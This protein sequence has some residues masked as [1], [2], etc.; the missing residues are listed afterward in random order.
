MQR[1]G[2]GCG[3]VRAS[4]EAGAVGPGRGRGGSGHEQAR[5]A[6]QQHPGTNDT[7]FPGI[8]DT[9]FPLK[10]RCGCVDPCQ[11]AAP[12][13]PF[14]SVPNCLWLLTE[15]WQKRRWASVPVSERR[16]KGLCPERS[17]EALHISSA[18]TILPT[19]VRCSQPLTTMFSSS[20]HRIRLLWIKPQYCYCR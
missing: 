2:A 4:G 15:A 19:K 6:G 1:E 13:R 7:P 3:P 5:G 12:T 14:R 18:T 20:V 16:G 11:P 17:S 8:N 10:R 9:P